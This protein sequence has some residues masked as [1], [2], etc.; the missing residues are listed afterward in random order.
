MWIA[1]A[2]IA[3][4]RL[5]HA[6]SAGVGLLML[7]AGVGALAAVPLSAV[8]IGRERIGGP[9]IVAFVAC[10]IPLIVVA[11]IPVLDIALFFVVAGSWDGCR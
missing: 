7:A 5:L 1:I 9:T 4:L 6:G 10:G 2:V 11:G 8:L 3:S